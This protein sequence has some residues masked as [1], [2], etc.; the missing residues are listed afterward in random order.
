M[1]RGVFKFKNKYDNCFIKQF[2]AR[3]P[4]SAFGIEINI[5]TILFTYKPTLKCLSKYKYYIANKCLL[6]LF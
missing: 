4:N 6:Q 5:I 2:K 1:Y 3:L